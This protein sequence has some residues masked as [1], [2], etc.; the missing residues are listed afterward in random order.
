MSM[1]IP[2]RQRPKAERQAAKERERQLAEARRSQE[3][4]FDPVEGRTNVTRLSDHRGA[5]CPDP[6]CR[7]CKDQDGEVR[8]DYGCDGSRSCSA[9]LHVHG[10]YADCGACD[11]PQEHDRHLIERLHADLNGTLDRGDLGDEQ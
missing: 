3:A 9:H 11:A 7:I 8:D 10:C 5:Y 4:L 6:Y 2:R 1:G